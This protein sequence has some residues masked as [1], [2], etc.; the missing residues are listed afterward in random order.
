MEI[1]IRSFNPVK[2][3][4][5]RVLAMVDI[6]VGDFLI[7]GCRVVKSDKGLYLSMPRVQRSENQWENVLVVENLELAQAIEDKVLLYAASNLVV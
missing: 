7:K 5:S 6:S 4:G 2:K 1:K 3:E